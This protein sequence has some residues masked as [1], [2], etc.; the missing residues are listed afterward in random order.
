MSTNHIIASDVRDVRI[1]DQ[2][3][4]SQEF[5]LC[6]LHRNKLQETLSNKVNEIVSSQQFQIEFADFL[7]DDLEQIDVNIQIKKNKIVI[8]KVD[9]KGNRIG[10]PQSM[11]VDK[12]PNQTINQKILKETNKIYQEHLNEGKRSRSPTCNLHHAHQKQAREIALEQDALKAEIPLPKMD[13][14]EKSYNKMIQIANGLVSPE[15]KD[16]TTMPAELVEEFNALDEKVR[17]DIFYQAY[18]LIDSPQSADAWQIGEKFFRGDIS[19]LKADNT[20]RAHAIRHF[21]IHSLATEFAKTPGETPPVQLLEKFKL[22]QEEERNA[23]LTQLRYTQQRKGH[24]DTFSAAY[25]SFYHLN[26]KTATNQERQQALIRALL[27]RIARYQRY[28]SQAQLEQLKACYQEAFERLQAQF[29][30]FL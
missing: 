28:A 7:P 8:Q 23:T 20:W 6:T 27:E 1:F 18:L 30:E 9:K 24:E 2:G 22:L 25:D 29:K 4:T 16:S 11:K 21:L 3:N 10:K 14:S 15:N 19:D 5:S 12:I 17:N 26:G 13:I